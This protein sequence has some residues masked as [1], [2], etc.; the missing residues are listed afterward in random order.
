MRLFIILGEVKTTP[1]IPT[2]VTRYIPNFFG[3]W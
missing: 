3:I 1:K 2:W